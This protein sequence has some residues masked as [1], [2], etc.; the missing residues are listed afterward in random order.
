[1]APYQEM[2]CARANSNAFDLNSTCCS[3]GGQR[4]CWDNGVSHVGN[5]GFESQTGAMYRTCSMQGRSRIF[6]A[7]YLCRA[8]PGLTG[9]MGNSNSAMRSRPTTSKGRECS[10]LHSK[11]FAAQR[12][13]KSAALTND[14]GSASVAVLLSKLWRFRHTGPKSTSAGFNGLTL[15]DNRLWTSEDLLTL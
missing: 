13:C 1:M 9:C 15:D 5:L 2:A 7:Y 4:H 10:E 11:T 14:G 6:L 12:G 8:K 3:K